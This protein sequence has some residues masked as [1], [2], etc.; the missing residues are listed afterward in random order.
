MTAWSVGPCRRIRSASRSRCSSSV[1]AQCYPDPCHTRSV[2]E[3][4]CRPSGEM[5]VVLVNHP[6]RWPLTPPLDILS[7]QQ[8]SGTFAGDIWG[9]IDTR[10]LYCAMNALSLLGR[11]QE[12]DAPFPTSEGVSES[13]TRRE[14]TIDYIKRCQN[15][16]GGF[17]SNIGAE[18]HAAQGRP[19][20]SFQTARSLSVLQSLCVQR[21]WLS[22]TVSISLMSKHLD[23]G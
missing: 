21:L 3:D 10:F 1:D 9:E 19:S 2:G 18:S 11:L 4:G 16:D 14:L 5:Y 8:P 12:L 7:L 13:R 22:L 6:L 23:G 17:G 15:Y 20:R